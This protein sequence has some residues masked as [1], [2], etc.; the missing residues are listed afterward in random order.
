VTKAEPLLSLRGITVDLTGPHPARIIDGVDLTVQSGRATALIGE[1]GSGKT[2]I[3][4]AVIGLL[5]ETMRTQGELLFEGRALLELPES[6]RRALR[7]RGIAMIFQDPLAALNPSQRIGRQVAE[8]PRRHGL[9]RAELRQTV[10]GLLE[11]A[12]IPRPEERARA[13]PH[14]LSGGLRQRAMIAMALSGEPRLLVADEP[15]TALDVTVQKR[16]LDLLA[17]L[18]RQF[19]LGMLFISHDLRVVSHVADDVVVLYAGRVAESGPAREVLTHP[20]HPYTRALALSV[21]SVHTA[22]LIAQP[23]QGAAANPADR[24]SGCAFHPRCP[25][26]QERCAVEVP[27]LRDTAPGRR[28]ACHFAA[29]VANA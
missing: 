1:S 12:G 25:L 14:Q 26:A 10:R 4:N 13:Y 5:P 18:Q 2:V 24:P 29:E 28:A 21:P 22:S 3:G 15:T 9:R 27:P 11:R 8:I 6:Q 20:C 17:G 7:G 23:I 19:G 16:I